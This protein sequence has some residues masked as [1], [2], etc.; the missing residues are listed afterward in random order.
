MQDTPEH[1]DVPD[2]HARGTFHAGSVA[3]EDHEDF[4]LVGFSDAEFE[5]EN[6][7]MLQRSMEFDDQDRRL[8]LDTYSLELA[9]SGK[10]R[11][12]YGG[13]QSL[14]ITPNTLIAHFS[15]EA[16]SKLGLASLLITYHLEQPQFERLQSRLRRI[17]AD[18]PNIAAE[19][20]A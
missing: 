19:D 14:S 5:T 20:E 11:I 3:V 2:S 1:P 12:V 15:A 8:R 4:W 6:Y 7:L 9:L 10:E 18:A 16:S 13:I 17:L